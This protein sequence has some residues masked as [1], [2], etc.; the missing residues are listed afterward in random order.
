[1]FLKAIRFQSYRAF[2]DA[3]LP[4][5]PLT[6]LIGPNSS[7]KSSAVS[8]IRS[9]ALLARGENI[10]RQLVL[11]IGL[12]PSSPA[13][14]T[15]EAIWNDAAVTRFVWPRDRAPHAELK[16]GG[17]GNEHLTRLQT[18]R[19]YVLDPTQIAATVPLNKTLEI[20]DNG[21]GLP[22]VLTTLQDQSP[23][24]FEGL[25][26]DLRQ[27]LPEFNRILFDTPGQGQRAITLRTAHG[28]HIVAT[29]KLS[30]GTLLSLTLLTICHLPN[31]PAIIGLEEPDY[32]IH[33]RLLR[34]LKD[35]LLRLTSPTSFEDKRDPVQVIVTTHS[36]Y[37]V[38]LF[39]EELDSVVL[40]KK[41]G[42]YSTFARMSDLPNVAE[43]VKDAALG[44]AWY[45]G[46]L[47]GV[48][49]GP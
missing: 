26:R 1:M 15:L 34:G 40:M 12:E 38:D 8:A 11:P 25:N 32:G 22:A 5:A 10:P 3:K 16:G 14:P 29:G 42:L 41:D 28:A 6:L 49:V 39:R 47:G 18:G 27:W 23:E 7:G 9:M 2:Q 36:P 24:R 30:A 43:I 20:Q 13:T 33:P 21:S 48:P 46:I 31:P 35:S 45:S 44:E 19:L 37:F 17:R 4:L